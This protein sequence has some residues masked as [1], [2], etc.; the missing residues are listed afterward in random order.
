MGIENLFAMHADTEQQRI[1][2]TLGTLRAAER[3]IT[4]DPAVAQRLIKEAISILQPD[5][6]NFAAENV[7]YHAQIAERGAYTGPVDNSILDE[8][9]IRR[10]L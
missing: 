2:R 6:G 5:S 10:R 3:V 1:G 8:L 7:E 4:R 9:G